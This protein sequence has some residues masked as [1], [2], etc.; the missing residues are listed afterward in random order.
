T[1]GTRWARVASDR[2]WLSIASVIVILG[3]VAL[4]ALH[5]QLGLPDAG[6]KPKSD[7]ERR[8]YD[9][10]AKGFGPGFNGPLTV[11]VDVTKRPSARGSAETDA[12]KQLT[13]FPDAAAVSTPIVNR[14]GAVF[15]IGVTPKSGP[16][17]AA[18]KKLVSLLR[19][20][21]NE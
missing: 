21:G 3:V 17:S 6:S 9:L 13:T 16:S 10:L 11:V 19:S 8:A 20:P 1:L 7:T 5:L 15:S 18:P 2:P 14:T 12:A 4:P